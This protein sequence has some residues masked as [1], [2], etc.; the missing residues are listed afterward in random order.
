MTKQTKS[1]GFTIV[2]L[3]IVIVVIAILAAITIVA[4]NGIQNRAND[5][6][7]KETASQFRTKIEAYN[8]IKSKYPATATTASALVTD[9]ATEAE[10]KL[11]KGVEDKVSDTAVVTKEKPVHWA[12]CTSGTTGGTITYWKTGGTEKFELGNC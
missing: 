4:Y 2:E 12:A 5:T 3:L 7:A 1:S 8:T 9:L 6:A 10:S 11:D